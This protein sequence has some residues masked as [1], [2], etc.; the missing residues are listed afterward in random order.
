MKT[1]SAK[2]MVTYCS[3]SFLPG[4]GISAQEVLQPSCYQEIKVKGDSLR[5][6]PPLMQWVLV[7]HFL[8]IT[9]NKYLTWFAH[10][11]RTRSVSQPRVILVQNSEVWELLAEFGPRGWWRQCMVRGAILSQ[12]GQWLSLTPSG[13]APGHFSVLALPSEDWSFGY[14]FFF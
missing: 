3:I 10:S 7:P 1:K 9:T 2:E 12:K 13:W 8:L 6:Y 4:M 5:K 14:V 11:S